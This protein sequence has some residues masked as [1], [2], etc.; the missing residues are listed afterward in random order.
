MA[1][2]TPITINEAIGNIHNNCYL[3]PA[4]QREFVWQPRQIERLFD[5]LMR[6]YPI[7]SFLFWRVDPETAKNYNFYQFITTYDQRKPHNPVHGAPS[8]VPG[9]KAVLDGQQRLTALNVGLHGS[10]KWKLPRLWWNNPCAFPERRLYLNLLAPQ[11]ENEEELSYKF[12]LLPPALDPLC[13]RYGSLHAQRRNDHEYWYR[14]GDILDIEDAA[15]LIDVVFD[16][17]LTDTKEPLKMLTRLHHVVHSDGI[18]SAYEEKNQNPER[19]LNVFVRANSGGTALSYSDMLLSMAVAQWDE[20]AARKEIH[21]LVDE[22]G[23]IGRGF[24]FNHDFVLKACL[25]LGDSD[26]IRFKVENF[27]KSKIGTLQDQWERIKRTITETVEL[28]SSFGYSR[29]SLT[30]ANALLPIAYF[31]HHCQSSLGAEDRK[32]IRHWLIRSLLK[33]E[34]WSSGA[35]NLLVAIRKGI[36]ESSCHDGFPAR[37]IEAAMHARR[38]SL[39]FDGEELE[40]LADASYDG[41]AY[42]LLFLLYSFV[43][44][45]TNQFHIDHVFPRALMTP[46]R[47]EEAGVNEE[48]IPEYRDQVNRLANLQLLEGSI[49]TSKGAKLPADWLRAQYSEE[50]GRNHCH[51]HDLGDVPTEV[52]SFLDFYETRRTRILEKLHRLLVSDSTENPD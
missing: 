36:R 27:R 30:S 14:V 20:V 17:G 26:S 49:N 35:D 24:S 32:T 3:L 10:G 47:L 13:P 19:V 25:M 29:Q 31:L 21:A 23:S 45:A 38:K 12:R 46:A 7:G 4:I 16:L 5:S 1:F 52:T 6:G 15:D 33:R 11:M 9:L 40:D 8:S 43:D 42:S 39:T 44:V 22:I 2:Q 28:V 48:Q 34:I 51:L 41:R 37:A 18:I 50:E